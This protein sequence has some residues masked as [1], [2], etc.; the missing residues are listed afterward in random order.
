[1]RI[2]RKTLKYKERFIIKMEK[3]LK[4]KD[5]IKLREYDEKI[6]NDCLKFYHLVLLYIICGKVYILEILYF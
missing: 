3:Q 4:I 6:I 2:G 1:M 5:F